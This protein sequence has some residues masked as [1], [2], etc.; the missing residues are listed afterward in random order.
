MKNTYP[1]AGPSPKTPPPPVSIQNFGSSVFAPQSGYYDG[2]GFAV[3]CVEKYNYSS[4][5]F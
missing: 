2:Y 1:K 3:R 5:K 4:Q